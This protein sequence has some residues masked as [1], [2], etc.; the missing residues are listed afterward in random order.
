MPIPNFDH[1]AF[2]RNIT[3]QIVSVLPADLN[4]EQRKYATNKVYQYSVVAGNALNQ[5]QNSQLSSEQACTVVQ[6]I[7][8]WTFYKAVDLLRSG[9]STQLCDEI[10]QQVAFAAF[11]VG[12]KTQ[13]NRVNLNEASST[14]EK[15]VAVSFEKTIKDFA[16]NGKIP[17][18]KVSE[19]LAQSFI[20]QMAQEEQSRDAASKQQEKKVFKLASIALLLKT[21]PHEKAKAIIHNMDQEEA[22]Q[23][24][25]FINMPDLEQKLDPR[26]VTEFLNEFNQNFKEKPP[27]INNQYAKF[28]RKLK[29]RYSPESIKNAV[30]YERST[31]K[32][33]IEF[34]MSDLSFKKC[35]KKLSLHL[36]KIL[37]DYIKYKIKYT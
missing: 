31:I 21:F 24:I 19:I 26:L 17:E 30:K 11:E 28:I 34:C 32:E 7:S 22:K 23:I 37:I 29:E 16:K 36:T 15:E 10:L 18:N 14:V 25:E 33:Y 4:E 12:K 1:E 9:L 27:K 5:D 8:E 20:D 13:I 35:P 6:F 3:Q 2:G